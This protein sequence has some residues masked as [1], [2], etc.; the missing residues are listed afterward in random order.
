MYVRST[1]ADRTLMS[2]YS[3]LA[4]MFPNGT[5]QTYPM[6]LAEWPGNWSPIPVHTVDASTDIVRVHARIASARHTDAQC[7]CAV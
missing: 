6:Y 4:G 5:N 3:N 2:A 1:D 7:R